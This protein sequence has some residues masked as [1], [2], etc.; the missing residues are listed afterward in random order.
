MGT[1]LKTIERNIDRLIAILGDKGFDETREEDGSKD[2]AQ[3]VECHSSE[4]DQR[5]EAP[6]WEAVW[7]YLDLTGEAMMVDVFL[8]LHW[9]ALD[10]FVRP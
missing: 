4:A 3:V 2:V 10:A 9:Y 6:L 7:V 8:S 5:E 1:E